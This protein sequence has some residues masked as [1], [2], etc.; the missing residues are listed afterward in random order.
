MIELSDDED[1]AP[2]KSH[3]AVDQLDDF[4]EEEE[5]LDPDCPYLSVEYET[6]VDLEC[7]VL[8]L[9]LPSASSL[10][11]SRTCALVDGHAVIVAACAD[12]SIRVIRRPLVPP[13]P[14]APHRADVTDPVYELPDYGIT[15]SITMRLSS[16]AASE[17]PRPRTRSQGAQIDGRLF[18]AAASDSVGFWSISM[19]TDGSLDVANMK[20]GTI[21]TPSPVNN[22]SFHPSRSDRL[23]LAESSGAVRIYDPLASKTTSDRPSS[24]DSMLHQSGSSDEQRKWI[25]AYHTSF[26]AAEGAAL[27]RRKKILDARW[28]MNGRGIFAL[29]EDG[30]WGIWDVTGTAQPGKSVADFAL[31]GFLG[32]A[33]TVESA[34]PAKQRR[35]MSK[36]APMTPN[37]RKAKAENL[38]T[39]PPKVAGVAARGGISITSSSAR[40]GQPDESVLMWYGSDIYSIPSLQSFWQRSM[41]STGGIGSLYSPGLTHITDIN[42]TN[43]N[44]TSMSQFASKATTTGLGQMNTK[45]DL[46]ISAEH[47]LIISQSIRPDAPAKGLFQ[48]AIERPTSRDQRMLDVGELDLGGMD[49]ML[50]SMAN[51]DGRPRRV[52][53][54]H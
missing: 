50:D 34:E 11:G 44:I 36:L 17:Q 10:S 26:Q 29:L 8:Q 4:E 23:L 31:R 46:L 12:K 40:S 21:R 53:F 27:A 15:R 22:V 30:E 47:R 51:G 13:S 20:L 7:A 45:R 16:E 49:R 43:E 14:D 35:G 25:M 38:F 19:Y 28:C 42:L 5:E 1:K 3:A 41:S 54:A 37:T 6:N 39:G 33:S 18:V 32:P 2:T 24:S 52:G 48:Q 9:A